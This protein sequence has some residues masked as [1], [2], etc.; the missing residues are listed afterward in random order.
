[1]VSFKK[2]LFLFSLISI[3]VI[4]DSVSAAD[5]RPGTIIPDIEI[6]PFYQHTEPVESSF[7]KGPVS[8]LLQ[9]PSISDLATLEAIF[10]GWHLPFEV[11]SE[12]PPI[13]K[14][15][16]L[17]WHHDEGSNKTLSEPQNN[18]FS[19]NTQ[20]RYRFKFKLD[21]SERKTRLILLQSWREQQEDITPDSAMVWLE[22]R[23]APID[24]QAIK[25]FISRLRTEFEKIAIARHASHNPGYKIPKAPASSGSTTS[26]SEVVSNYQTIDKPV[27]AVWSQ[28]ILTLGNKNIAI[29]SADNQR[30]IVITNWSHAD[31]KK[32]EHSSEAENNH[33]RQHRLQITITPGATPSESAV[34]IHRLSVNDRNQ[35]SKQRINSEEKLAIE[36]SFLHYL[37]LGK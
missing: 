20:D 10:D 33:S 1:M 36:A 37:Q 26:P 28:L 9:S 30:H 2:A 17:L 4:T 29:E 12:N 22:W 31:E 27:T 32:L 8:L 11:I 34:F 6:Y 24:E 5:N 15:D 13:I 25:D 3:L 14:T 16:W 18:F 19:I 21:T 7:D 35:P 23:T